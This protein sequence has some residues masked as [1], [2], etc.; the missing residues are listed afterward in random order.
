MT[1]AIEVSQIERARARWHQRGIERYYA[2]KRLPGD[3]PDEVAE[4]EGLTTHFH[5]KIGTTWPEPDDEDRHA[6]V[7]VRIALTALDPR[8]DAIIDCEGI[9]TVT[10][11]T[12]AL[13]DDENANALS[14]KFA[15]AHGIP[16]VLGYIRSGFQD[17]C[18][19]VGIAAPALPLDLPTQI[20]EGI[21]WATT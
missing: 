4:R 10:P 17:V 13:L 14:G 7:F 9:F 19:S 6:Y 20:A 2:D 15:E 1:R 16:Y 12:A 3:I 11:E 5:C 18:R 21:D 8:Y